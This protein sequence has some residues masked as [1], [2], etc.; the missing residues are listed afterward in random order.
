[1][2]SKF[3][4]AWHV[5]CCAAFDYISCIEDTWHIMYIEHNMTFC[6]HFMLRIVE[7]RCTKRIFFGVTTIVVANEGLRLIEPGPPGLTALHLLRRMR[8][9]TSL[10]DGVELSEHQGIEIIQREREKKSP[11]TGGTWTLRH[12]IESTSL[13]Y[14]TTSV[15]PDVQYIWYVQWLTARLSN[16]M[17]AI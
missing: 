12:Q 16:T 3:P 2:S 6:T 8:W 11:N 14:Q 10:F 7:M 4:A 9:N 5:K 17:S 13:N 15:H 1:M